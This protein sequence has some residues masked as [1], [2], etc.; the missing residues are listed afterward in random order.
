MGSELS[1]PDGSMDKNVIIF[2]VDMSSSVQI[3]N[4]AR[5]ILIFSIGPTQGLGD[6]TLTAE[7]QYS[8]NFSISNRKFCLSLH[9]NGSNSFLFVSATKIYQ[10]TAKNSETIKHS[11]CLGNI[12]GDFSANS[13]KK[14]R[15]KW[16]CVPFF[17]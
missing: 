13:M 1:L 3:D 4:K 10:F 16:V 9:Y 8:I 11:L 7:A 15:I 17:C 14:N 2:G 5:D 6:A 12:S